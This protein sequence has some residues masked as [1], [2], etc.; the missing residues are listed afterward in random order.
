M[1]IKYGKRKI[2]IITNFIENIGMALVLFFFF[3]VFFINET[4]GHV[5][6]STRGL[7]GTKWG[8]RKGCVGHWLTRY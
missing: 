2:Q 1:K 6:T 4:V 5:S 3:L 8:P 7:N